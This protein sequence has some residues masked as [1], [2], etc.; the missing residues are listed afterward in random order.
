MKMNKLEFCKLLKSRGVK[1]TR[2]GSV[3]RLKSSDDLKLAN[4]L[5]GHECKP[6]SI[7]S[8]ADYNYNNVAGLDYII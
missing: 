5:A 6:G 2:A 3:I 8:G 7:F 4:E 1:F